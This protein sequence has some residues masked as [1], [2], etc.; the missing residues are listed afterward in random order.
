MEYYSVA[1][2]FLF[3]KD[4]PEPKEKLAAYYRG[5]VER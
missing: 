3:D 5:I 2:E 1:K 4:G